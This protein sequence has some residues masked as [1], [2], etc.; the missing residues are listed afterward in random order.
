MFENI[1]SRSVLVANRIQ[2]QMQNFRQNLRRLARRGSVKRLGSLLLLGVFLKLSIRLFDVN[3]IP[4]V[5]VPTFIF[6]QK[7]AQIFVIPPLLRHLVAFL[8]QV[9]L[10]I[11]IQPPIILLIRLADG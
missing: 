7:R 4:V 9:V 2:E 8:Q 11:Q 5:L 3:L 1:R 6:H 10:P